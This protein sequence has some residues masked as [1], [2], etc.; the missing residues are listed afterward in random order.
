[1]EHHLVISEDDKATLECMDTASCYDEYY[2]ECIFRRV[3][4][5]SVYERVFEHAPDEY[6]IGDY[7]LKPG[8]YILAFD[9]DER[10]YAVSLHGVE[11]DYLTTKMWVGGRHGYMLKFVWHGGEYIDISFDKHPD[12][13]AFEVINV[14]NSAE[15]KARIPFRLDDFEKVVREYASDPERDHASD[16]ANFAEEKGIS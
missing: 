12:R 13:G 6:T 11:D 16:L 10:D 14:W 1:M 8:T 9:W 5:D 7:V 15:D 3:D 4:P 2:G